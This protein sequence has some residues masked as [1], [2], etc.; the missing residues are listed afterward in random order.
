MKFPYQRPTNFNYDLKATLI[1]D[2][3]KTV[4]VC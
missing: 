2:K 3:K 1:T 4:K